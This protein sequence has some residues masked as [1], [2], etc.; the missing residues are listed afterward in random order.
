MGEG[1]SPETQQKLKVLSENDPDVIEV[2]SILSTYQ[3]PREVLLV[4]VLTFQPELDTEDLTDAIDRLR[5]EIK[6]EYPIITFVIIQ[7]QSVNLK[8]NVMV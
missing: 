7:P 4:L 8:N 5:K 6:A 3:S 2:K 1:L